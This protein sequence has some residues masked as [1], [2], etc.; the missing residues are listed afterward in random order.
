MSMS[1]N[2]E[3]AERFGHTTKKLVHV[4][5]VHAFPYWSWNI[6]HLQLPQKK[7]DPEAFAN[8]DGDW[9]IEELK[10]EAEWIIGHDTKLEVVSERK[11]GDYTIYEL[12]EA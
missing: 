5:S 4:K 12:K 8:N 10:K 3:L 9:M 7:Q 1:E 11:D 2:R 6:E